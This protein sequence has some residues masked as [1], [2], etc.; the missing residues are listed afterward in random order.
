MHP[1]IQQQLDAHG[2]ARALVVLHHKHGLVTG[3]DRPILGHFRRREGA[4]VAAGQAPGPVY[5][6]RLELVIGYVD[7]AGAEALQARDDVREMHPPAQLELVAPVASAP[8]T[9]SP[10]IDWGL[11]AIGIPDL[12]SQGLTGKGVGVAHLDTGVD[13]SHP[14]LAGRVVAFAEFDEQ[15]NPL[16]GKQPYDSGTHGTHTAGTIAGSE[17]NGFKIGVAPEVDLHCSRVI[18]Y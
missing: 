17:I 18:E 8:A 4:G 16:P 6:K 12:W 5:L 15:G 10:G 11:P 3:G 7:P 1:E 14:A 13:A 9:P 2:E